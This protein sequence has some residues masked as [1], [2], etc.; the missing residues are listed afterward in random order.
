MVYG[1]YDDNYDGALAHGGSLVRGQDEL[2]KVLG[3]NYIGPQCDIHRCLQKTVLQ[4]WPFSC[5]GSKLC[6]RYQV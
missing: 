4:F 6:Q 1:N 2:W 3:T 5:I